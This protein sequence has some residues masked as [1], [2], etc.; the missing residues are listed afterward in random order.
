MLSNKESEM[1]EKAIP[2]YGQYPAGLRGNQ[3]AMFQFSNKS[4]LHVM[5]TKG[6]DR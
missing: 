1:K 4:R 6:S 3:A 2:Q 5:A